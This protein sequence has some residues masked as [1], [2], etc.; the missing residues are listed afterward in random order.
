MKFLHS[1]QL[2]EAYEDENLIHH[3]SPPLK[4]PQWLHIVRVLPA[5]AEAAVAPLS[6]DQSGYVLSFFQLPWPSLGSLIVTC[7][8]PTSGPLHMIFLNVI[9]LSFINL[10]ILYLSFRAQLNITSKGFLDLSP[11]PKQKQD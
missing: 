6:F 5:L 11:S 9:I 3:L 4:I 8:F 10:N 1:E 7:F 2:E